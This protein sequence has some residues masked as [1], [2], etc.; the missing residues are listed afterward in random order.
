M[1][2]YSPPL[3]DAVSE[4]IKHMVT[5]QIVAE[6]MRRHKV[7][8]DLRV[9]EMHPGG[10]QGDTLGLYDSGPDGKGRLNDFRGFR[11]M[12][13]ERLVTTPLEEDSG[14][15]VWPWLTAEDPKD[16]VDAVERACR[17]EPRRGYLPPSTPTVRVFRLMAQVLAIACANRRNLQWRSAL[18]DSSGMMGGGLR[19]TFKELTHISSLLPADGGLM[20]FNRFWLLVPGPAPDWWQTGPIL[21]VADLAG[22]IYVGDGCETRLDVVNLCRERGGMAGAAAWLFAKLGREVES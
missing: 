22:D 17:L 2:D 21:A 11:R 18:F 13:E 15:Y 9:Y 12:G 14:G 20:R 8:R 16:V 19:P 10:G 7:D 1:S 5:W 4:R 3:S 6:L